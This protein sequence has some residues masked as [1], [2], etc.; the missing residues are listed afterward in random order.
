[1]KNPEAIIEDLK[2]VAQMLS[3]IIN[4]EGGYGMFSS[5]L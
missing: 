5:V 1:M 3:E 4:N 2:E